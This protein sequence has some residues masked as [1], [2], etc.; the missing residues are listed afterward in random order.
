MQSPVPHSSGLAQGRSMSTQI[1]VA[2]PPAVV[3]A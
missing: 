2:E 3:H 1:G